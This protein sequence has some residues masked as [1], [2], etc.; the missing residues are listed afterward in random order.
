MAVL[1]HVVLGEVEGAGQ[2]LLLG[3]VHC[4]VV[5]EQEPLLTSSRQNL[6]WQPGRVAGDQV[7]LLWE[8]T[9]RTELV[10]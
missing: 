9:R 1:G 6:R 8:S 3:I 10:R 7:D 5:V 2:E 4:V